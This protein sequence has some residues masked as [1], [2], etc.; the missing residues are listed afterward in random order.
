MGE[1]MDGAM[2]QAAQPLRQAGAEVDI[3]RL[4]HGHRRGR[5]DAWRMRI[6]SAHRPP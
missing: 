5:F 6:R 1:L 3:A 2:Q 4:E